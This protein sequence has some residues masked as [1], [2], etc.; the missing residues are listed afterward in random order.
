MGMEKFFDYI[1]Q[2][3]TSEEE[4]TYEVLMARGFLLEDKR[5]V[6]SDNS[7]ELDKKYL[8]RIFL[9]YNI[10]QIEGNKIIISNSDKIENIFN[11]KDVGGCEAAG[12]AYDWEMFRNRQ[13]GFK[14]PVSILEPFVARY[15]K[16]ISACGI[17]TH[18]SCDGNHPGEKLVRIDTSEGG[19]SCWHT[20]ICK[21]ILSRY[22]ELDWN[23]TYNE[24]RFNKDNQ[25]ATY[26]ELNR[27]ADFLYS[28][29]VEFR[30]V[31]TEAMAPLSCSEL[32][33]KTNEE[34]NDIFINNVDNL[35]KNYIIGKLNTFTEGEKNE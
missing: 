9:K 10:G 31:K 2:K 19:C 7:H 22:F 34:L 18:G 35:L 20:F 33:H 13:H 17:N 26:I 27:A 25:W 30:K 14:V 4:Y 23:R 24:I 28:N 32:R 6:L 1:K 12:N 8:E 21:K 3:S 11:R 5:F 29:R 16:A 15:I